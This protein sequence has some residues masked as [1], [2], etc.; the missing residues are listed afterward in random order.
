VSSPLH[1]RVS[2]S[3]FSTL[4]TLTVGMGAATLATGCFWKKKT[5]SEPTPQA[6]VSPTPGPPDID[7]AKV[8]P[9]ELGRIP[10]LMYHEI[11]GKPYPRD[12]GLVRTVES[13]K[14]DLELL[15]AAGFRPVNMGDVLQNNIDIPAGM[16]PVVITFDDARES[17][18]RLIETPD[19]LKVDPNCGVGVLTEF[20]KKHPDWKLR[21]TFFV[22]PK[23]EKT[24]APFGQAGMGDQKFAY[25][26]EKGFELANHT[27][28]H[29]SFRR[30]SPAEIQKEIG[31][32][33]KEILRAVPGAK[34]QVLAAPMGQFPNDKA[35]WKY[36]VKGTY[37][38][39]SYDYKAAMLAAYRPI[40]S[41]AS[42]AFDPFRLERIAPLDNDPNGLRNW[43]VKLTAAG[44]DRYI[45]DGD[46]KVV[47]YPK[48]RET[49]V[50][51]KRLEADGILAN[52]Y[53]PFGG[54]GGSKP[55][56]ADGEE[57][58]SSVAASG[59]AGT[60]EAAPAATKTITP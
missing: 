28:R 48:G 26:H 27:T 52:A 12:P 47:S 45:S 59:S 39:V 14:K 32:A 53:S 41:P 19:S 46:P 36:L 5:A 8:R 17:Q 29:K 44:G 15:Y 34:V 38:G 43:I 10:V 54:D 23:S 30:M 31:Y 11:G 4:L 35:N 21:A 51:A 56:V 24:M 42:K 3:V 58:A 49:E 6:V 7:Y 20:N 40:P 1:P 60:P 22:L 57:G 55:I 37:E 25:L 18:F 50:N 9:N 2:R 16:S 13:F 33:H